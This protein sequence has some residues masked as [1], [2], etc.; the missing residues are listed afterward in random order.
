MMTYSDASLRAHRPLRVTF[1]MT[2]PNRFPVWGFSVYTTCLLDALRGIADVSTHDISG[3]VVSNPRQTLGW[4]LWGA[5]AELLKQPADVLHCPAFVTPWRSPVPVVITIHDAAALRFPKDYPLEWVVYNRYVLPL[6]AHKAARIVV[7][8]EFSRREAIKYYGVR[9]ERVVIAPG[10][11]GP[12]Y[13]P[14]PREAIERFLAQ[15]GRPSGEGRSPLILFS[16]APFGRKNLDVV[17]RA[18]S[19]AAEGS[20]LSEAL[21]LISGATE[22]K[23]EEYRTRIAADGLQS[24]VRWLGRVPHESMPVLYGA[25][26][27]LVYPSIYEGF[28]LP[29]VEAMSVGTPV[30]A[31]SASCLPEV[32]GDAALLVPPKD[33]KGFGHAMNAV[34]SDQGRREK[35]VAAGKARAATFTWEHTARQTFEAY[36]AAANMKRRRR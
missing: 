20:K 6:L 28:G 19:G 7:L 21:L 9:E 3:P 16:G 10:A 13:K 27:M 8:T 32:L 36:K 23:F 34:L 33:D 14:Q 25:V 4:L 24:R 17:L 22:S 35:M 15:L 31:A 5:R 2:F 11:A 18:M 29:P 30:V 1:D 12:E 26:D